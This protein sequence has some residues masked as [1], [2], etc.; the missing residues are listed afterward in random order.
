MQVKEMID[1]RFKYFYVDSEFGPAI[2]V[3]PVPERVLS[4]Y[5]GKLPEK[6]LQ[7]WKIY[8]F[9]GYGEGRFWMTDPGEYAGVLDAWLAQTDFKVAD[10]YH[11]IGR[12]AFGE[13]IIWG[14]RSGPSL[15]IS[16]AWGMIFPTDKSRWMDQGKQDFLIEAWLAGMDKEHFDEEDED[17]KPLFERAYR[18]LGPL[19][20][21]EMYG[22]VPAAALGGPR[23]LDHLQKVK[24]VEHL[25]LLSMLEPP[26]V[27]RD[28]VKEAKERGIW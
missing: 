6:L 20:H 18:L 4:L 8:G 26:K 17:E 24:A 16:S 9:A 22:F 10:D 15:T 2:D 21:D 1:S 28:I 19:A 14:T 3:R 13:L 12:G 23:R 27:M 25:T 5:K 11:V 7:Y